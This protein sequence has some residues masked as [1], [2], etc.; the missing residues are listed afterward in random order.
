MAIELAEHNIQ[1]NC[2]A[3]TFIRTLLN[4]EALADPEFHAEVVR[5]IPA[6]HLGRVEDVAG[7]ALYLCSPAADFVTGH[8]LSVDGGYVAW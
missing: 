4:E 2:I 7:A 5:R 6:H 8:C 1:V 3:P